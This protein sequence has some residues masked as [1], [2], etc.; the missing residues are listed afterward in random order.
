LEILASTLPQYHRRAKKSKSLC[1]ELPAANA[2]SVPMRRFGIIIGLCLALLAAGANAG[3]YTL[4]DGTRLTGDP[5]TY[6]E[7]GLV[8]KRS[9]GAY[10]PLVPWGRFTDESLKQLRADAATPRERAIVEPMITEFPPSNSKL[11]EI[12]V[13]PVETPP[14]PA[15][16]LGM[17]A[18]FS[19]PVG[20]FLLLVLYG[21]N[22]FAAYEVALFRNQPYQTVCGY[23]AVP[24]L[25]IASTLY[26]LATPTLEPP[27]EAST[28]PRK[29]DP[30]P[31]RYTTAPH[32]P[33]APGGGCASAAEAEPEPPPAELPA[34]VVY[35][36]GDYSFNRRFFETK[37]AGFFRVVLGEA[38]KDMV[39]LIKSARGEF[40]GKRISRITPAELYLQIFKEGAS[41]DEMIPFMEITEVQICHKNLL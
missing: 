40:I 15:G 24:F 17:L 1:L 14:R 30:P 22:L 18:I 5:T 34:P 8:L 26:F 6:Q 29:P 9:D 16:R 13:K 41:A 2:Q 10:S 35:R 32:P 28:S 38:E 36:R 33:P 21:A 11:P 27:D 37:L 4:T 25:G 12:A 3:T 20:W 23:A 19:S 7:E 31:H 39:I